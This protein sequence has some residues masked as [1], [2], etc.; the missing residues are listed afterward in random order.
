MN[1][2]AISLNFTYKI[3]PPSDGGKWGGISK[4]GEGFGLVGDLK[5]FFKVIVRL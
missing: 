1:D 5:V 4:D 2:L 3:V